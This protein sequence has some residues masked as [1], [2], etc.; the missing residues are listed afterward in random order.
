MEYDCQKHNGDSTFSQLFVAR[1]K[2]LT[3][4]VSGV[5]GEVEGIG[6]GFLTYAE[7]LCE[8]ESALPQIS[9]RGERSFRPSAR[10]DYVRFKDYY[11]SRQG[12]SKDTHPDPLVVWT[13][14][15]SFLK[16]SIEAFQSST[17][18]LSRESFSNIGVLGKNRCRVPSD[19]RDAIYDE[20]EQYQIYLQSQNLWD[21]CDRIISLIKRIEYARRNDSALFDSVRRSKIYVDETQVGRD[22]MMSQLSS[23]YGHLTHG[24]FSGLHSARAVAVFYSERPRFVVLGRRPRLAVSC[25]CD[26]YRDTQLTPCSLFPSPICC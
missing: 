22:L 14:I 7:L 2:R 19:L 3:K 9:G 21:D 26:L 13:A 25:L 12:L 6:R 1:S 20:F 5:L 8:L 23:N 11:V 15:R 24:H 10:V 4:Y 16:N 18:F 17:G